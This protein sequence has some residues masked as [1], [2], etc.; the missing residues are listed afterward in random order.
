MRVIGQHAL[1]V[2]HR[3][4][5]AGLAMSLSP[6]AMCFVKVLNLCSHIDCHVCKGDWAL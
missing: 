3:L 1:H 6:G 2:L 4:Y 5:C